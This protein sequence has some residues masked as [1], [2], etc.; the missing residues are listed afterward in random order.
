MQERP[1]YFD[2]IMMRPT[3]SSPGKF[4]LFKTQ[5]HLNDDARLHELCKEILTSR[6]HRSTRIERHSLYFM[7]ILWVALYTL[8]RVTIN[9]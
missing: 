9:V 3:I 6:C 5:T 1:L 8:F 4:M 7:G 2:L